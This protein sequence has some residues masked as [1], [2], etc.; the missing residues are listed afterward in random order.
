MPWGSHLLEDTAVAQKTGIPKMACPGKRKHG[1]KPE[2]NP[3]CLI[4]SHSQGSTSATWGPQCFWG[5]PLQTSAPK[6]GSKDPPMWVGKAGFVICPPSLV[7]LH[8]TLWA[9]LSG[10][11]SCSFSRCCSKAIA[12]DITG[13]R[14][15]VSFV[16]VF[17]HV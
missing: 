14:K 13:L 3:S 9:D 5:A 8:I 4:L 6:K 12:E 16:V 1:P 2:S 10:G 17:Q 7:S 11:V 15:Q